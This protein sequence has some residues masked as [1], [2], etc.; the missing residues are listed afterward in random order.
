MTV[1]VKVLFIF[2]LFVYHLWWKKTYNL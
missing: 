2:V 1:L